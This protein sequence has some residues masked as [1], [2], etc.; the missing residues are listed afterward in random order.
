MLSLDKPSAWGHPTD[1]PGLTVPAQQPIARSRRQPVNA[2]LILMQVVKIVG[3]QLILPGVDCYTAQPYDVFCPGC[4]VPVGA[5][6]Q[7]LLLVFGDLQHTD[8]GNSWLPGK[9]SKRC[10][11]RSARYL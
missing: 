10:N 1:L 9:P 4:T 8:R 5:E 2:L 6:P 11:T 7:L 3:R